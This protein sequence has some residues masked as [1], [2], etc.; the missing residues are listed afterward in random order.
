[1]ALIA[2][3]QSRSSDSAWINRTSAG[4]N[5]AYA[6]GGSD[7]FRATG[8]F[9]FTLPYSIWCGLV[10]ALVIGEWMQP[11]DQRSFKSSA[12]LMACTISAGLATAVS[13]SR[14]A[15]LLAACALI[16]G[17]I[18]A[19]V[20]G[21]RK[22]I[23]RLLAIVILLPLMGSLALVLSPSSYIGNENRFKGEDSQQQMVSRVEG[24]IVGFVTEPDFSLLGVGIGKG[25]QAGQVGNGDEYSVELSEMDTI[26]GVQE[27]GTFTGVALVIIRYVGAPVI[28]FLGIRALKQKPSITYSMPLALSTIPTFVLGDIWRVAPSIA[29]LAYYS[30]AIIIGAVV[31][32]RDAQ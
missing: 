6:V 17:F 2:T 21:N 27:L 31:F 20:T 26:R 30:I 25:I 29:T 5:T 11:Q 7:V 1:M 24:M 19:I 13:G 9:N 12:L 4:D 15:Y 3:I 22:Y 10:V 32:R 28:F 16:G 23:I 14:T 8:T 18:A